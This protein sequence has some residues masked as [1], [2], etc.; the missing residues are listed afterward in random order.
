MTNADLREQLA[1]KVAGKIAARC[2]GVQADAATQ[3]AHEII[4][5]VQQAIIETAAHR[6]AANDPGPVD[7]PGENL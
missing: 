2:P 7:K 5:L 3:L 6:P 1:P 4:S